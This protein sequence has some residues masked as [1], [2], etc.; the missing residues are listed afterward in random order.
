[1]SIEKELL[2]RMRDVLRGLEETHYDLYWDIQ[3]ELEKIEQKPNNVGYLYKQE[4][5]YGDIQTVFKIDKPYV[6]WHNVT[7]VVPVYLAPP[8]REPAQTA[9]EMYQRGYAKAKDDLKREPLSDEEINAI[10]LPEKQCTIREFVR[11]I[12]KTHGIGE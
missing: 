2:K 3:S 9:R 7:D 1:M 10:D 12:E 5:C 11:I 4:D 6:T 8:K